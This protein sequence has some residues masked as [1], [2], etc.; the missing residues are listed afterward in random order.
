MFNHSNTSSSNNNDS[1]NSSK[2]NITENKKTSNTSSQEQDKRIPPTVWQIGT[3]MLLMNLSYVIVYSFSGLYLKHILSS[4]ALSI[5]LVEGL[6]ETVSYSMKLFSGV[7]SD[8]FRKR[9]KIIIIGY[10]F[11]VISKVLLALSTT[12]A[13]VFAARLME[14]FGNGIQASPR[15]AIVADVAPRNRI[16]VS[17]GIKRSLAYIG[18]F[19]GGFVG[20][21]LMRIT[22]NDYQTVFMI[23]AIPAFIAFIIL[24]FF[25]KEPRKH[26]SSTTNIQTSQ[27]INESNN[28]FSIS[29][30]KHLGGAFWA[31]IIVNTIFMLS[32]MNETFLILRVNEN[33]IAD[34]AKAPIVMIIMNVGAIL[35]SY[36][37][38]ILGD[39]YDRTR[40][41]F[42]AVIFLILADAVMYG[43]TTTTMMYIGIF[44]WGIQVGASQNV[45]YSLIAEKT[46]ENLRGTG[47]GI[48]WFVNAIDAFFADTIAGTISHHISLKYVFVSSGSIGILTLLVLVYLMRILNPTVKR[49]SK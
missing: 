9:K 17:Y 28:K 13:S 4:T 46:P 31:I 29:N 37:C 40:M 6:C 18:S 30:L 36:P 43:A 2:S 35:S 42:I 7:L 24:I 1:I 8:F 21:Y 41:L 19:L 34:V 11:S 33:F 20:I 49:P 38:G 27:S 22:N 23:A 5:G 44:L 25:V 26:N 32:R 10:L 16:G 47:L 14:R 3:M 48:Y 12:F 39:K 15:D 45:F